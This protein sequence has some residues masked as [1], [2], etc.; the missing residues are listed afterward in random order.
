MNC[1]K[2]ADDPLDR[3][4]LVNLKVARELE[5]IRKGMVVYDRVL[6]L[7]VNAMDCVES[8]GAY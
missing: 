3:E 7:Q 6:A 8:I 4:E 5:G 2:R 1:A